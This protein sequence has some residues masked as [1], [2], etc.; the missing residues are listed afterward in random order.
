MKSH[1]F[2]SLQYLIMFGKKNVY[3]LAKRTAQ[4]SEPS[5][6]RDS[7]TLVGVCF[8]FGVLGWYLIR[9]IIGF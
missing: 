1:A 7:M 9:S 2:N 5:E 8:A 3:S 6:F 4:K